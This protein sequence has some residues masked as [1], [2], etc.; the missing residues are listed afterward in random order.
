[1]M[2]SNENEE[3]RAIASAALDGIRDAASIGDL[4]ETIEDEF[5]VEALFLAM[6]MAV[7]PKMTAI[8]LSHSLD[9]TSSK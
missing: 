3:R 8:V 5:L 4:P 7:G 2:D 6:Q 1:M 9:I